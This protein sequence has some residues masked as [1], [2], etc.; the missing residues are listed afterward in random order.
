MSQYTTGELATACNVSVR[1][2]Q[3]YDTKDLLKPTE[4]TEGGRR[5]YSDDDLRQLR[6]ICLLKALGL[7]LSSI[8]GI[9]ESE[10]KIR[11]LHAL[12]DEQAK[13]I[14]EDIE[15]KQKQ[16]QTI[17][18]LQESIQNTETLPVQSI[19]DIEHI[20][21]N[22]KK[23]RKTHGS[24]LIVGILMDIIEIGT[25]LLWIFKGIWW[26]FAAGMLVVILLAVMMV[27]LYRRNAAYVCANCSSQFQPTIRRLLFSKHTA[28][29][30]LLT[31][32]NCKHTDYCIEVGADS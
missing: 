10:N 30:R 19:S 3:F 5:L 24:M 4:L 12:L 29:T 23:L 26:P 32:P 16:L 1:T 20:M 13:H 6:L 21:N 14:R 2:V 8:K 9:L 27:R 31:C 28:K 7:Q 25:V 17:K 15:D 18:L 22:Q 11:V